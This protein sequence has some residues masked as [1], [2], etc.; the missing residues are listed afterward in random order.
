MISP[1]LYGAF[2]LSLNLNL[3]WEKYSQNI[4]VHFIFAVS[5]EVLLKKAATAD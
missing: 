3:N 4:F 2:T 5:A 1:C